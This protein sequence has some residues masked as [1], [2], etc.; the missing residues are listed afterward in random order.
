[1]STQDITLQ[2]ASRSDAEMLAS[3]SRDLIE[4]GLG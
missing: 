3:M 2:I 4:A 1:M